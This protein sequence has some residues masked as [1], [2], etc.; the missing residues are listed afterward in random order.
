MR[1]NSGDDA[2]SSQVDTSEASVK[3]DYVK[4]HSEGDAMARGEAPSSEVKHLAQR[5]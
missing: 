5:G 4:S 3:G 1:V 2:H